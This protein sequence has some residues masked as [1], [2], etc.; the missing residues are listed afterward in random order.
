VGTGGNAK[1]RHAGEDKTDPAAILAR[2]SRIL[3]AATVRFGFTSLGHALPLP[4]SSVRANSG[5]LL[6]AAIAAFCTYF[7]MYAFRKPFTASS[8][9]NAELL[10]FGLK[11]VLVI[12]Q[13]A[14]YML[15]KFIG[16]KV[17]SEMPGRWRATAILAL[18]GIAELALVGF[19]FA[20]VPVKPVALFLNGLP[21]GMVFGLVMAYLEGRKQTE[22]LTAALCASFIVSSGVV[23]SVGQWLVNDIGISEF[24]MP[25]VAGLLFLLPLLISVWALQRT[26][27]PRELDREHRAERGV[28]NRDQRLRFFLA[29]WPGLVLMISVYVALTVIRTIRDDFAVEIWRDMGVSEEPSVFARSETLVALGV[30]ALNAVAIWITHNL[31]AIRV[32]VAMMCGAFALAGASAMLQSAGVTSPF[33]FM[34]ACGIG[35][36]VPYVAFHTTLFERLV[37]LS[38]HP[39]NIGFLMYV[40][41]AMGYLGYAGIL[42]WRTSMQTPGT[43]LP[44]FRIALIA[45]GA[46]CIVALLAALAYF[47]VVLTRESNSDDETSPDPE[48]EPA[49]EQSVT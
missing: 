13:L 31:S 1:G 37:A 10:G 39:G 34:V 40:A 25:M 16:I 47:Q 18:I 42:V 41:D 38:R 9:A 7:C 5:R 29:Y 33:V 36:Y 49:F 43:V 14:G 48:L 3:H 20:P 11:T 2:D 44:F 15:S 8:Y 19:A 26:P 6:I 46:G 4:M 24:N 32:T 21:L 35:L 22:A 12:A 45:V 30:T 17:I 23:K 28:M 27:P